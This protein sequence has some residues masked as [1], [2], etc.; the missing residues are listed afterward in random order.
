M[1]TSTTPSLPVIDIAPLVARAPERAEVAARIGE[2]C[3]A[4]GF[5][6]VTG[7]GV[8]RA[9]T[10][11]LEALSRAFFALPEATKMQWRMELGGRAWRGYFPT[12]GELTSGRPD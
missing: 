10:Q 12:G 5:F 11:R 3:R 7:H 6:Y 4:H 1:S 9:L 8:D 2:A